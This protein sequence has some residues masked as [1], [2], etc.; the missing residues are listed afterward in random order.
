M[1]DAIITFIQT[2]TNE[3]NAKEKNIPIYN[4]TTFCAT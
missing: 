3:D 1:T 4:S 2:T